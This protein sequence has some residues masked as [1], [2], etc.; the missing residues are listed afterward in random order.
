MSVLNVSAWIV[1]AVGILSIVFAGLGFI[2]F[3]AVST[4][5]TLLG[6][7][8]LSGLAALINS[9][10]YKRWITVAL[11]IVAV[12]ANAFGWLSSEAVNALLFLAFGSA[13]FTLGHAVGKV[14]FVGSA[15]KRFNDETATPQA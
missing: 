6:V 12:L 9:Q 3:S 11:G 7:A 15:L 5:L 13:P 14:P 8:G 1:I 2:P 10:G 4:I